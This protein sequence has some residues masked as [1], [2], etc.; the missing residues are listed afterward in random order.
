M[1]HLYIG[2]QALFDAKGELFAYELFYRANEDTSHAHLPDNARSASIHVLHAVTKRFDID[3]ILEDKMAFI[4]VDRSFL[5]HDFIYSVPKERFILSILE[6][7]DIDQKLQERLHDLYRKGYQLA[8]NDLTLNRQQIQKFRPIMQYMRY[9]K[10]ST[11]VTIDADFKRALAVLQ[12]FEVSLIAT[13]IETKKAFYDFYEMGASYFQ[14]F[15]FSKPELIQ[16]QKADPLLST[17][18]RLYRLLISDTSS[19]E[20]IAQVF[21]QNPSL[22]LQ[23]LKLLNSA[24]FSLGQEVSNIAQALTLIGR[25]ALIDWLLLLVYSK[26]VNRGKVCSSELLKLAKQRSTLMETLLEKVY[27]K[28]YKSLLASARFMGVLSLYD[29]MFDQSLESIFKEAPIAQEIKE[30]LLYHQGILGELFDLCLAV[31]QFQTPL[32]ERFCI[33]H[34][35]DIKAFNQE[36]VKAMQAANEAQKLLA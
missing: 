2:R 17:V 10:F 22:S 28:E 26:S 32:I 12:I 8:V 14:G 23:M 11:N 1:E 29:A 13:K 18:M 34:H 30:G 33:K 9:A 19:L 25:Q 16:A 35:L 27:K 31:E 5:L 15:F 3:T 20:E 24:L 36:V 4:K 7:I 6:E 21:E